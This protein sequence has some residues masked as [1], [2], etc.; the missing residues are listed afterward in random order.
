MN[1]IA[2]AGADTENW[3]QISA[4]INRMECERVVI[5]QASDAPIFPASEKAAAVIAWP[6]R[7]G[8]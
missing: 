8:V 5:V 2:F 1:L 7:N 3:G 6:R 4:L